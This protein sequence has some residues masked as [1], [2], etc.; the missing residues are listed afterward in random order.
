VEG[1]R[2]GPLKKTQSPEVQK[3]LAARFNQLNDAENAWRKKVPP[4]VTSATG[5]PC[6][7]VVY[8]KIR[9]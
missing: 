5:L 1:Q 9:Y 7:S 8:N 2:G 6:V 3:S 4:A